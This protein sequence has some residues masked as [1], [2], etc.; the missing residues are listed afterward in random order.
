MSK[1]TYTNRSYYNFIEDFI[2]NPTAAGRTDVTFQGNDFGTFDN[3]VYRN[4]DVPERNYQ[5]LLLQANYRAARLSVEGHWTMQ[6]KN[7]GNFEGEA[8]NQPAISSPIGDYPEILVPGRNY[9]IGRLN[10]FQ[11]HKVRLWAIYNQPLGHFGSV[12]LAPILRVDSG[13]A[14]SL[15]ATDVDLSAI[16][17]ARDPG[18]AR[19]PDGGTQTIYFG[20]RGAQTFKGYALMDLAATYQIPVFHTV[21]PWVKVEILNLT[22]NQ[23]LISWDTTVTPDPNSPLDANGLPTG[24]IQGPRFGQATSN[25]NYPAWRPGQTGGRTYL[26][27]AGVRF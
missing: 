7:E 24:Y 15:F 14:Y 16:Q 2:D 4:T 12:D 25:T 20:D 10:D 8:Q 13:L 27:S 1:L 19:L 5:A 9:P 23:K 6:L 22:N 17:L 11:R 21:S 3:V 26:L 18:Y